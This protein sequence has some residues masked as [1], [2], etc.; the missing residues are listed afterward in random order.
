MSFPGLR[1]PSRKI[2]V[3]S[4]PRI[5]INTSRNTSCI[6]SFPQKPG[7]Y[8]GKPTVQ[9]AYTWI[10]N[11]DSS[12]AEHF[13]PSK[14]DMVPGWWQDD[15][16]AWTDGPE[17]NY[18]GKPYLSGRPR[19]AFKL[20]QRTDQIRVDPEKETPTRDIWI[21]KYAWQFNEMGFVPLDNEAAWIVP[22]RNET[23]IHAILLN[24]TDG[25][26][27][28][29]LRRAGYRETLTVGY[30]LKLKKIGFEEG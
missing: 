25:F 3:I 18:T 4:D 23:Y 24:D 20:E 26:G 5:S 21:P 14:A 7:D 17:L 8:T 27:T 30:V 28:M 12:L 22:A 6:P 11:I 9:Y 10:E 16:Q 13:P 15:L 19:V 2:I 29:N 1:W